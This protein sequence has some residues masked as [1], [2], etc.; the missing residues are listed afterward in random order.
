MRKESL[1]RSGKNPDDYHIEILDFNEDREVYD[2]S[3]EENIINQVEDQPVEFPVRPRPK[4]RRRVENLDEFQEEKLPPSPKEKARRKRN[5]QLTALTYGFVALFICMMAYLVYYNQVRARSFIRDP[6]NARL[7]S[8]ADHVAR[9]PI[10]DRNGNV[11]AETKWSSDGTQYRN[12]PEGSLFAHAVGYDSKGKA[13]LESAYNFELLTSHASFIE[14]I[15]NDLQNVKNPGDSVVTTLDTPLQQ[16]ASH[17][18]GSSKGA[19]V[20]IEPDTGKILVMYSNPTFDPGTV[21]ENWDYLTNDSNSA[22]LNRV[23]QGAYAPGS[24]FKIVTALEY[25]RGN[26]TD[27]NYAYNCD[28]AYTY[29][30][31]TIHCYNNTAHGME[32][33]ESSFANSCNASFVNIGLHLKPSK[34]RS[35]AQDL[36]FNKKLPGPF[37][38]KKSRFEVDSNTGPG[39]LMMTAMGQGNTQISPYHLALIGCAVANDGMLMR[40]YIV[41]EIQN[42]KEKSVKKFSPKSYR[43]LM[44]A[45]E[46][47]TLQQYMRAVVTSGTGQI[48]N[49]DLYTAACKTGTAEYS[50]DKSKSHSTFVGYAN[51][52]HPDIVVAAVVENADQSGVSAISIAKSVFDAYYSN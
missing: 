45:E 50:S 39:E 35:T 10:L 8:M 12:Y 7:D 19:V 31:T 11:L 46:A 2:G 37:A 40:P 30:D 15:K 16:A 14:Q 4:K 47:A 41:S 5:R 34:Y 13:G 27:A 48:L 1:K 6:H 3:L 52:D 26:G 22:L 29:S 24:T 43:D 28:G 23:M 18:L 44:S 25:L 21:S 32:T 9:G 51:V 20:A 33:L 42:D 36:L 49:N 17:A 38:A